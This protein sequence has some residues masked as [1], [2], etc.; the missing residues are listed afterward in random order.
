MQENLNS[1]KD[2]Y[3]DSFPYFWDETVL[4][5]AY[6]RK[7]IATLSPRRQVR[8]LSLGIGRQ[9]VSKAIFDQVD[10]AEYHIVEG[11][12]DIIERYRAESA[13][14]DFVQIHHAYF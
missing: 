6:V 9:I 11:A 7:L 14:P 1:Y 2:A 5:D 10:L 4:L 12:A 8:V 3:L 13:P